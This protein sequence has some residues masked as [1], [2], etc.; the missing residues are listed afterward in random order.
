MS[1]GRTESNEPGRRHSAATTTAVNRRYN[2]VDGEILSEDDGSDFFGPA[3]PISRRRSEADTLDVI[4]AS[5]RATK[6]QGMEGVE[7]SVDA[8]VTSLMQGL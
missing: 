5:P 1:T 4:A 2:P 3:P 7:E 8:E 6:D